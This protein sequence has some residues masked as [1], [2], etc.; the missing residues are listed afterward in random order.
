MLIRRAIQ[1]ADVNAELHVVR[2]GHSATQL[3][4]L[5]DS[6][7]N[8]PCPDLVLLDLNLPK[9]NGEDVLK[10][11]RASAKCGRA[12]VLIVTS[13]DSGRDREPVAALGIA[14]YFKKPSEYAEFMKLGAIV[15]RLLEETTSST[16][17]E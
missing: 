12:L 6:D 5:A 10:R 14:G 7:N 15:K 8:A 2:D 3:F 16:D 17:A 11:L 1:A 13:S 4:D 9:K